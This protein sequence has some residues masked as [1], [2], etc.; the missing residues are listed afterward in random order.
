MFKFFI[1]MVFILSSVSAECIVFFNTQSLKYHNFNCK[2][3]LKCTKNCID[4]E[5]SKAKKAGGIPCEVCKGSCVEKLT[6]ED[7][8]ISRHEIDSLGKIPDSLVGR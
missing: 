3:A 5:V 8:G 7:L 2:W 6:I 4:I 1:M